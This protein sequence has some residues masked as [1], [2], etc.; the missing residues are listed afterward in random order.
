MNGFFIQVILN[1]IPL[2]NQIKN[3]HLEYPKFLCCSNDLYFGGFSF[4]EYHRQFT[5]LVTCLLDVPINPYPISDTPIIHP[6][7]RHISLDEHYWRTFTL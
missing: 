3:I 1:D 4:K 6:N 2:I 5:S 7:L